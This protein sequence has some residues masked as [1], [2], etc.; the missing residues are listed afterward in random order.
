MMDCTAEEQKGAMP[1]MDLDKGA[2]TR[3][4]SQAIVVLQAE[5]SKG[6]ATEAWGKGVICW[7][8]P[9][10]YGCCESVERGAVMG[11]D[12][13]RL[14]LGWRRSMREPWFDVQIKTRTIAVVVEIEAGGL[15]TF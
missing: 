10:H 8:S 6:K 12:A 1:G 13:G 14:K 9:A 5:N 2:Q 7:W 3:K 11:E 15:E 4:Y